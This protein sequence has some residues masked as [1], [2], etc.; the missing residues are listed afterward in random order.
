[1]LKS[2][3]AHQHA[4]LAEADEAARACS[5]TV[6]MV[7]LQLINVPNVI[8]AFCDSNL[9]LLPTFIQLGLSFFRTLM[10]D[11]LV[12]MLMSL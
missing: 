7:M 8:D 9:F 11:S 1:M 2:V 10:R 6:R 12:K 3:V 5:A 4:T